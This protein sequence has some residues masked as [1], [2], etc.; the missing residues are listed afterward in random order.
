MEH[1]FIL[2]EACLPLNREDCK[3]KASAPHPVAS[4]GVLH[5]AGTKAFP[6]FSI[7]SGQGRRAGREI[8]ITGAAELQPED[9]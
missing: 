6:L 1:W 4:A 5:P 2:A 8:T 7:S 9:T 3:Q